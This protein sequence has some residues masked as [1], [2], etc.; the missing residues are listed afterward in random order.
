MRHHSVVGTLLIAPAAE[1]WLL[2]MLQAAST[3]P[4]APQCK[5]LLWCVAEKRQPVTHYAPPICHATAHV[6]CLRWIHLVVPAHPPHLPGD[7]DLA[8]PIA[9]LQR[10]SWHANGLV[11]EKHIIRICAHRLAKVCAW[12]VT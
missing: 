6:Q 12:S 5:S 4:Y 2:C 9:M 1:V 8:E 10:Q 7:G 11:K 3:L